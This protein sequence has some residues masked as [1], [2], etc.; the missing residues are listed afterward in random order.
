MSNN[1]LTTKELPL[2]TDL[3]NYEENLTKKYMLYS[4]ILTNP[5]LTERMANLGNRHREKF[6]KLY[7]LL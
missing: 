7:Q 5:A 4:R 2:L 3:L 6:T 1:M